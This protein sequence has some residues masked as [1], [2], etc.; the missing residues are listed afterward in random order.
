MVEVAALSPFLPG[1]L[2]VAYNSGAGAGAEPGPQAAAGP[3]KPEFSHAIGG[4]PRRP[5]TSVRSHAVGQMHSVADCSESPRRT[6]CSA[7]KCPPGPLPHLHDQH[8]PTPSLSAFSDD[9]GSM[10]PTLLPM[11]ALS[12]VHPIRL[13]VNRRV[14]LCQNRSLVMI[15][16]GSAERGRYRFAAS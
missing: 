15:A 14:A 7:P 5:T 12:D 10:I 9:A 3:D 16:L 11:A 2:A 13:V 6:G 8:A 1:S 4:R